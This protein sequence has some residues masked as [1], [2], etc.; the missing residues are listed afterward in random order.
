[1][2]IGRVI[3]GTRKLT[4]RDE[5]VDL[6]KGLSS[7]EKSENEKTLDKVL[8]TITKVISA[9]IG[10]ILQHMWIVL[11]AVFLVLAAG[12][13][14]S[15][16]LELFNLETQEDTDTAVINTASIIDLAISNEEFKNEILGMINKNSNVEDIY[17]VIKQKLEENGMSES[18]ADK[19]KEKVLEIIITYN[20]DEIS[21]ETSSILNKYYGYLSFA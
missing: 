9:I 21:G 17:I 5:E 2:A 15:G 7:Q 18:D 1:M 10:A 8:K 14:L 3:N 4:G 12:A 19:Y 16:F 13:L 11:L 6:N 20:P